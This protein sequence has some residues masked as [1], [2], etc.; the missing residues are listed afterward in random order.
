VDGLAAVRGLGRRQPRGALR[1]SLRQDDIAVRHQIRAVLDERCAPMLRLLCLRQLHL[2]QLRLLLLCLLLL[3]LLQLLELA[4]QLLRLRLRLLRLLR[5]RL[6]WLQLLWLRLLELLLRAA[7]KA[8]G[9]RAHSGNGAVR[10]PWSP[11][12]AR[13]SAGR[14]RRALQR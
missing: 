2:L 6:L 10:P 11:H 4:L 1:V 14:G 5:L 3:R 13:P 12:Q 9:P 8:P 7:L